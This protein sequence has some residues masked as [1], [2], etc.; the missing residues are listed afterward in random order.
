[1][2]DSD[3][4]DAIERLSDDV[5]RLFTVTRGTLDTIQAMLQEDLRHSKEVAAMM[6]EMNESMVRMMMRLMKLEKHDEQQGN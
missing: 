6:A 5:N 1:M 4:Q 3:Q 2:N